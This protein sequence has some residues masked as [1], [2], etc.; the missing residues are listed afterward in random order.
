M[1]DQ[2]TEEVRAA[3]LP[4]RKVHVDPDL[5]TP[6]DFRRAR[7]ALGGR[8]PWE[9]LRGHQED[10]PVLIAWC[11]LSRDDPDLTFEDVESWSFGEYVIPEDFEVEED[12]DRPLEVPSSTNGSGPK[13][14]AARRSAN[15][16]SG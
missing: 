12:G 7:V 2:K 1:T 11:L 9:M 3:K 10:R 4:A 8:D 16:A 14:T 13:K 15:A 6:R 5:L